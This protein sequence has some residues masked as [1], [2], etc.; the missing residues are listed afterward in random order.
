MTGRRRFVPAALL[1]LGLALAAA[2]CGGDEPQGDEAQQDET[3][4]AGTPS[5]SSTV[6][7]P[8]FV[9]VTGQG[10]ELGFGDTATVVHEPTQNRGSV[11]EL[12][13][14]SAREARLE[15]FS[16]YTLDD[17]ARASTPYYVEVSIANVGEGDLG[18]APVPLWAV[19]E[20]DRLIQVSGFTAGFEPCPSA[21]LPEPF[22]PGDSVETCL[23]YLLPDGGE[24][25][26]LSFR[27]TQEFSPIIWEGE[28]AG[29][30]E[31]ERRPR[32]NR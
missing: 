8:H 32:R 6:V 4:A 28:V 23:V 19:D 29:P 13:V 12:T 5:P 30:P 20:D 24:L 21:P 10:S 7:V 22:R 31:R 18:R 3:T 2:G 27:P 26:A 11:L 17:R 15:D 14:T 1:A 9:Q 16:D 25:T